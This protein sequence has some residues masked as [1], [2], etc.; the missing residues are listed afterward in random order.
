MN[1]HDPNL[2]VYGSAYTIQENTPIRL[3]GTVVGGTPL[4]GLGSVTFGF[5]EA[6]PSVAVTTEADYVTVKMPE[7]VALEVAK[8]IL[9]VVAE[10]RALRKFHKQQDVSRIS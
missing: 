2:R 7:E 3:I 5:F 10:N 6:D 4:T 1:K 9:Q 8:R